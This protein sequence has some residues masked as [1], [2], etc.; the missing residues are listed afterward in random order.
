MMITGD[1]LE[2]AENIGY[3]TN[4]IKRDYKIHHLRSNEPDVKAKATE[5]VS[6][7]QRFP[8]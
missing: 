3:L 1:K 2:T 8:D 7:L 6:M 5:I 4:L